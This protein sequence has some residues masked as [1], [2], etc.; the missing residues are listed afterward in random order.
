MIVVDTNL[1][2]CAHRH[3]AWLGEA[4]FAPMPLDQLNVVSLCPGFL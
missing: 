3:G 2:A 1:L 4:A